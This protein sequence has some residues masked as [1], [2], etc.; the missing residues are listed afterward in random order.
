MLFLLYAVSVS[1]QS[2]TSQIHKSK[3]IFFLIFHLQQVP[4]FGLIM[5]VKLA[6]CGFYENVIIA[7]KFDILYK[8]LCGF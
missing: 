7:K 2:L 6:S 8:V 4:D 1:S 5:R 3:F